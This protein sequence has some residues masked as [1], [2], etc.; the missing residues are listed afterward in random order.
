[1]QN[2]EN[3]RNGVEI[4]QVENQPR[5]IGGGDE[6]NG[7]VNRQNQ[8]SLLRPN[9]AQ[10]ILESLDNAIRI[11]EESQNR[12]DNTRDSLRPAQYNFVNNIIDQFLNGA[13]RFGYRK[14]LL[15]SLFSTAVPIIFIGAHCSNLYPDVSANGMLPTA[16]NIEKLNS[17]QR[18]MTQMRH[19]CIE[20]ELP[21]VAPA[22][23]FISAL[24]FF[25][26]QGCSALRSRRREQEGAQTMPENPENQQQAQGDQPRQAPSVLSDV[27]VL[28]EQNLNP[29]SPRQV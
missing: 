24:T 15:A 14:T 25:A 21:F 5:Q 17:L 4:I 12:M 27:V 29:N 20:E 26:V 7:D 18:N 6:I 8:N 11:V 2:L 9:E 23:F 10:L 1:M 16:E 13:N 28:V 22:A 19:N 3:Q